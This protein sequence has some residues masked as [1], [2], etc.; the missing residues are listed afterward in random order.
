MKDEQLGMA[1]PMMLA[2]SRVGAHTL[3][4][5][6]LQAARQTA[7]Q[8]RRRRR[9]RCLALAGPDSAALRVSGA[10]RASRC[11]TRKPMAQ[12][13]ASCSS[14]LSQLCLVCGWPWCRCAGLHATLASGRGWHYWQAAMRGQ[15]PKLA[16]C[17]RAVMAVVCCLHA[18]RSLH[19]S[20]VS[21]HMHHD[22]CSDAAAAG[23]CA[24]P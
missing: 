1:Q 13:R 17:P 14:A 9:A 15:L 12:F 11:C 10:A 20:A 21:S 7:R 2:R 8:G 23:Y 3:H 6:A 16:A 19:A 18:A 5:A 4:T 24:G 22:R